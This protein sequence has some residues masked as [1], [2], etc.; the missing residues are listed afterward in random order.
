VRRGQL[1]P[2]SD[3]LVLV[4]HMIYIFLDSVIQIHKALRYRSSYIY[5]V[6]YQSTL[7]TTHYAIDLINA[8]WRVS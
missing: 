2:L 8:L 1:Y 5:K 7:C 6:S 4:T 3:A